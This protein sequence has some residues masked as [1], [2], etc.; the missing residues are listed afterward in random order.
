MKMPRHNLLGLLN[1]AAPQ[2]GAGIFAPGGVISW[3][4]AMARTV[5]NNCEA[6]AEKTALIGVTSQ[7][8]AALALL[9][10]DGLAKRMV[11]VP[12]DIKG[13]RLAS[14]IAQAGVEVVLCDDSATE[15]I[16]GVVRCPIESPSLERSFRDTLVS[17]E[18]ILPTSG[19]TGGPKLVLHRLASLLGAV[20]A[21]TNNAPAPIWGTFYDIRR[22][23]GMQIF[24]RAVA[25]GACLVVTEPDEPLSNHMRR[26][27]DLGVTHISGTPS[28][29]RRVLMSGEAERLSPQYVRLS[30][31]VADR[32]VLEALAKTFPGAK[33]VHAYASTEAGVGF[34]VSD[35]REGFPSSYLDGLPGVDIRIEDGTLRLRSARTAER[36]LGGGGTALSD[37]DGFVDTGDL[38]ERIDDRIFFKGRRSGAINVGGAKVHPEEVETVINSHEA[39]CM[40]LVKARRSPIMGDLIVADV[41]L[42]NAV[43]ADEEAVIRQDILAGCRARLDRHKAPVSI[44][45][46]SSLP[47]SPAG[48]LLRREA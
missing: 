7:F 36:Y 16:P 32:A 8:D 35:V 25:G 15:F 26:M 45:F 5:L 13:E 43:S 28:H 12:T 14:V 31:E 40:S 23:G 29:W 1:D 24:L 46:V 2:P 34:E 48:K 33:I 6:V 38:V 4:A 20:R 18:W 37:A 21:R 9:E 10:L 42:K 39:V 3:R 30:G 17:T 22:F 19:T 44:R 47:L 41:V 11:V 27:A